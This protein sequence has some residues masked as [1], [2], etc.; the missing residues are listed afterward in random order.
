MRTHTTYLM[1]MEMRKRQCRVTRSALIRV[2][3]SMPFGEENITVP[4]RD[5]D[6]ND[7]TR[8]CPGPLQ[9]FLMQIGL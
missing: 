4:P 7:V 6:R 5:K 8:T 9:G 2:A 3:G 1:F